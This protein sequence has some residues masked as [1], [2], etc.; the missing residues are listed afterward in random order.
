[1]LKLGWGPG[2]FWKPYNARLR[3]CSEAAS[4]LSSGHCTRP[5]RSTED[6]L[7]VP[8]PLTFI[9]H[10]L[11][12]TG[13]VSAIWALVDS[14]Q[15]RTLIN[16]QDQSHRN[17]GRWD[18]AGIMSTWIP[19]KLMQSLKY[20]GVNLSPQIPIWKVG[21]LKV[22][23]FRPL[24]RIHCFTRGNRCPKQNCGVSDFEQPNDNVHFIKIKQLIS[25]P[26]RSI[27]RAGE[28]IIASEDSLHSVS[29]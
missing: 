5:M 21:E 25:H 17:P 1:M 3:G 11:T 14:T 19:S 24:Q 23:C 9:F 28:T 6:H 12:P 7:P 20:Y 13:S 16:I 18:Y 4:S 10:V 29:Q 22:K 8:V 27:L 15:P 2:T 26:I